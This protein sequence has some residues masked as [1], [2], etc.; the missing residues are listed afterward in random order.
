MAEYPGAERERRFA[1]PA[2]LE[3]VAAIFGG[4]GM[5]PDDAA[6]LADTLVQADARGIHSHGV[7][8]VPDYVDKLTV[9]GV[10]PRG[11]PRV[12]H[13]RFGAIR[14]EAGNAM[15]QIAAAFAMDR[16]I[17]RA[18]T[19]GV[20]MASVGGS[21]HCGA[22]DYWVRMAVAHGMIGIAA[23]NALPTMAPWGG[24][25]KIVGLNPIGIGIPVGDQPP[26]V[27]DIALGATA[28]GKMRIYKQKGEPIPEGW[29]FDS[30]GRPTTDV[31][32][33]LEGLIQPIGQH[34]GIGL[35]M[36]MGILSTLLSGGGY[37]TESGNMVDGAK[38]GADGQFFIAIDVAAFEDPGR[39]ASR[40]GWV[41]RQYHGSR[42]APGFTRTWVP[43]YLEAE[44]EARNR[45]DGIP[46][47][48]ATVAG[49][50]AAAQ[51]MGAEAA[52]FS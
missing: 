38:A 46:L 34:K 37:G 45:R 7:M 6:L 48:D 41:V 2:L 51:R 25:D 27:L 32:A 16:A 47:N 43:G 29:A 39:F 10:D 22:M 40:M 35:A 24:I 20:A 28:H 9:G 30:E 49:L 3:T 1:Y 19:T 12:A 21:N 33:A 8:R 52:V 31:D 13:E 5:A 14:V 11:R 26:F 44:I 23:T 50:M 36:A 15:G 17:E 18:R 42:P 4:C